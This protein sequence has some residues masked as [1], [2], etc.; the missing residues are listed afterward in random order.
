MG[1]TTRRVIRYSELLTN[2]SSVTTSSSERV[3]RVP[4]F[5]WNKKKKRKKLT[6]QTV[7]KLEKERNK[8]KKKKK[9]RERF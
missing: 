8:G 1:T 6:N 9:E 7:V 5:V 3:R 2:I 4:L